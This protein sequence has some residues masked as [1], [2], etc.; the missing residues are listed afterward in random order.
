MSKLIACDVVKIPKIIYQ[1]GWQATCFGLAFDSMKLCRHCFQ[2]L[3]LPAALHFVDLFLPKSHRKI[4]KQKFLINFIVLHSISCIFIMCSVHGA[5]CTYTT[6]DTKQ[7]RLPP[8]KSKCIYYIANNFSC[9]SHLF[10]IHTV[11]TLF[12]L[13]ASPFLSRLAVSVEC[14]LCKLHNVP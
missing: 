3:L 7:C 12:P 9:F 13:P 1:T 11:R 10:G 6:S 4:S 8:L 2:L 5:M 14:T